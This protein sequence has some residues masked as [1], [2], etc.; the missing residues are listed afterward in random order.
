MLRF[1]AILAFA[2]LLAAST[3]D[4]IEGAQHAMA[5]SAQKAAL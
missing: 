2:A 4:A 5:Y 1:L 3:L